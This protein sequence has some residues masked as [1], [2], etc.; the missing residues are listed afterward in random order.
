MLVTCEF[1]S[2]VWSLNANVSHAH[3]MCKS[4]KVKLPGGA[5][6]PAADAEMVRQ[7]LK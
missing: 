4:K 5:V 6:V 3:V 2:S 1:D 7:K